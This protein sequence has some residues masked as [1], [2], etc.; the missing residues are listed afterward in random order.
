MKRIEKQDLIIRES[1]KLAFAGGELWGEE[2]DSLSIHTDIVKE[3]FL[4]DMAVIRRPSSPSLIAVHLKD[5]L[6]TQQ[7]AE[8]IVSELSQ[9]S[10]F[11]RK[12]A[13]VGLDRDAKRLVMRL[14]KQHPHNF[15][16]NYMVD[17]EKAKEWLVCE[18]L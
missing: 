1:M 8:L 7:L 5:T 10:R 18:G 4:R 11:I 9:A 6:V 15:A 3:K 13:F 17:Y 12:L 14:M 16:V 2:L